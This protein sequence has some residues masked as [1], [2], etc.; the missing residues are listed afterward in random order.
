MLTL[1]WRHV[2]IDPDL[3]VDLRREAERRTQGQDKTVIRLRPRLISAPE[4]DLIKLV[5]LTW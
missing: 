5:K 4:L 2:N 1:P 3:Q